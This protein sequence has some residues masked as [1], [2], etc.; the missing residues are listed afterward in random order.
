VLDPGVIVEVLDVPHGGE[1][2]ADGR[3]D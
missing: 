3:V 2:A 1:G